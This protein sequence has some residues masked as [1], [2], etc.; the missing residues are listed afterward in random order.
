[1]CIFVRIEMWTGNSIN[2]WIDTRRIENN[3][4]RGRTAYDAILRG[5]GGGGGRRQRIDPDNVIGRI[6]VYAIYARE[7][8]ETS[9]GLADRRARVL[10]V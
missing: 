3:R 1:V 10:C 8:L 5:G 2:T 6:N 4:A 7:I 9:R